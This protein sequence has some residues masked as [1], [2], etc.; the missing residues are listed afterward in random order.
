MIKALNGI[1]IPAVTPF[2]EKE[3]LNCNML[4]FNIQK[5][6]DTD[7]SGYMCLGSN[8]E[9]RMLDDDESLEVL[10]TFSRCCSETKGLIAGIGRESLY[11]TLHFLERIEKEGLDIDY[12]S[13]LTPHYFKRAMDDNALITYFEKIADESPYPVLLYCAP[14]FANGVCI[15]AEALL[16]LADHPNIFGIKD[17]S[18]DQMDV[19]MDTVGGRNDFS[20]MAGSIGTLYQCFRRGGIAGVLSAA[21]YFPQEC[22]RLP[23]IWLT[24][25]EDAYLEYEKALRKKIRQTGGKNGVSSVK[26]YMNSLGYRAGRPR[27][28]LMEMKL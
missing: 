11:Q 21:N 14:G 9:F 5:W 24:E 7:V 17:T 25:G 10:R 26:A 20:V 6:N 16:I 1:Y 4:E 13:V 27:S 18:P 22:A 8:G 3:K 2:D 15:S 23:K 12:V 28:P 19:Y